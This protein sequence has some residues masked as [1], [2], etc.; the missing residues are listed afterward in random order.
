[1]TKLT[2]GTSLKEQKKIVTAWAMYDWANSV[3]ATSGIVAIF[4]VYFV[5]L[6]EKSVQSGLSIGSL[7]LTSSGIWSFGILISTAIVAIT[8]PLL[9]ILSDRFMIKKA[10]L[11]IYT[12]AGSVFTIFTFFSIYTSTPWIWFLGIFILANIGYAGSLVFYNSFLPYLATKEDLDA[13]SSKGFALGYIGG[14]LLLLVHLGLIVTTQ[15]SAIE[16]L[17]TRLC[18]ASIGLWWFGW[19]I[20]TFKIV[21][22]P[23][24]ENRSKY[25]NLKQSFSLALSV[26]NNTLREIKNFKSI[27]IYLIAYLLFNDGIQTILAI[28]GAFAADTLRV[29]LLFNMVTILVIQFIAAPGSQLFAKLAKKLTTKKALELSL[30]GWCFIILLGIGIAPLKPQT[31]ELHDYQ[32]L[33]STESQAYDIQINSVF[34]DSRQD[35]EWLNR[36]TAIGSRTIVSSLEAREIME[37][38]TKSD[39]SRFSISIS[40]GPLNGTQGIGPIHPANLGNG[41]L[42]WWPIL[43]RA[44]VWN[45]LGIPVNYQWLLLGSLVGFVMGGSQALARSIF[46]SMTPAKRSGEFFSFYGFMNKASAVFGPLLYILISGMID[47]RA[48]ILAIMI[49]ILLGIVVLRWVNVDSGIKIAKLE[50]SKKSI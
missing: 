19:G 13:V 18:M 7:S 30:Y 26:L 46:A 28:A 3:F 45:P 27:S 47:T 38:I 49:L 2:P 50:D 8:S 24:I 40:G 6:F 9:G 29:T 5:Y 17:V 25:I 10:L 14:G 16:D 37:D 31:H 44:Q 4:P 12:F 34:T 20:W 42:D 36:K 1:M 39:L 22:E 32:L 23:V 11:I 33:Y 41:P 35:Q 15:G 43:L 21:P 48:A